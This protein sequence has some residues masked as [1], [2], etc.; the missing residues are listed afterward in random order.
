M[1]DLELEQAANNL[2]GIYINNVWVDFSSEVLSFRRKI[3]SELKSLKTIMD[4]YK[5]LIDSQITVSVQKLTR[6]CALFLTLPVTV[7]SAERSF[8]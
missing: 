7:V 3:E 1:S 4:L 2:H 5:L 8:S 6:V